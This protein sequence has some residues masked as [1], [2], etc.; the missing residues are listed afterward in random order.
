MVLEWS[1]L[2]L[3]TVTFIRV[4]GSGSGEDELPT[5]GKT[6]RTGKPGIPGSPGKMGPRGRAGDKGERGYVGEQGSKGERVS[7]LFGVV[8]CFNCSV[9]GHGEIDQ[10]RNSLGTVC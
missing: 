5:L 3:V 9:E 7:R 10:L 8:Q 6:T 1:T 2:P 4:Q